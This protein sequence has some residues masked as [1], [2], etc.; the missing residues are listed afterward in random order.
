MGNEIFASRIRKLRTDK[1][2]SLDKLATEL[3]INKSRIGMWENNG[4]VHELMESK[5]PSSDKSLQ[6]LQ[7][8]L[9]DLDENRLKKAEGVLKLMFDDIFNDKE[10]EDDI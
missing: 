8:K 3:N 7:R 9:G 1:G 4:T 5:M 6:Y 10:D 2:L